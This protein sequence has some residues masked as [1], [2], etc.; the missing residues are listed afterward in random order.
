M[1]AGSV[2]GRSTKAGLQH[3]KAHTDS[4]AL[5]GGGFLRTPSLAS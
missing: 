1:V 4:L 5:L 2:S 3:L